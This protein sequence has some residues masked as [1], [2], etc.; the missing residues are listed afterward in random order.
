[1]AFSLPPTKSSGDT[2]DLSDYNDIRDSLAASATDAMAAKGDLAVGTGVDA[3]ARLAVGSNDARLVTASGETTG[4][5]WQLPYCCRVYNSG[6]ISVPAT[7]WTTLTFDTDRF[8]VDGMHSTSSNTERITIPSGGD[9]IYLFGCNLHFQYTGAGTYDGSFE[10]IITLSTG[11]IFAKTGWVQA[12]YGSVSDDWHVALTSLYSATAAQYAYVR[13][14]AENAVTIKASST[15]SP[16]FWAQ[17][18]R[19]P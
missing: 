11:A 13:V 18:Q 15:W 6:D 2:F 14:Y 10:V 16:E 4:L 19:R 7:T 1:M 3:L 5:D 8:D 17:F 12:G 9:G